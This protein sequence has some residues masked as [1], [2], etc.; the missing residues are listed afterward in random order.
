MPALLH[1]DMV[2]VINISTAGARLIVKSTK[3]LK[4]RVPILIQT[5]DDEY[6]GLLCEPRWVKKLGVNLYVVG[7]SFPQGQEDLNQLKRILLNKDQ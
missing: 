3:P 6:A 2:E 4:D 5:G 7:V 1:R